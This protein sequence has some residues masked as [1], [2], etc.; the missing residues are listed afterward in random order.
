MLSILKIHVRPV[1]I[2]NRVKKK[3][4][5]TDNLKTKNFM[6][7]F[8]I[9][10]IFALLISKKKKCFPR[11]NLPSPPLKS[12]MVRPVDGNDQKLMIY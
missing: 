2:L 1:P 5:A 4:P 6:H 8:Y 7:R 3:I 12:Q 11:G 9:G 10:K